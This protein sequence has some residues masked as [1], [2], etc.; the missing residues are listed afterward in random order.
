M[1]N[2]KV[3]SWALAVFF[4]LLTVIQG[5]Y[6]FSNLKIISSPPSEKWARGIKISSGNIRTNMDFIET[7]KGIYV[8]HTTEEGIKLILVDKLGEVIN[9]RKIDQSKYMKSLTLIKDKNQMYLAWISLKGGEK[10]FNIAGIDENL[11]LKDIERVHEGFK[12]N[13]IDNENY[14]VISKDGIRVYSGD[15]VEKATY[16]SESREYIDTLIQDESIYILSMHNNSF[17]VDTIKDGKKLKDIRIF[18]DNPSKVYVYEN[19]TF[20]KKD[21]NFVLTYDYFI[22]TK[23][24]KNY[25]DTYN[26]TYNMESKTYAKKMLST[27]G[28]KLKYID[29][30]SNGERYISTAQRVIDNRFK[31]KD[32]MEF[33]LNNGKVVNNVYV[34]HSKDN[35]F[36]PKVG[37]K[38]AIYGDASG[39]DNY[40]VYITSTETEFKD[41]AN[42]LKKSDYQYAFIGILQGLLMSL[43]YLFVFGLSWILPA[44]I[45]FGL[46]GFILSTAKEKIQKMFFGFIVL[47]TGGIQLY[48][49]YKAAY[50]HPVMPES[51][52]VLIGMAVIFIIY[53][54]S[55]A[56]AFKLYDNDPEVIPLVPFGGILLLESIIV[57]NIFV[58][59]I[60][61]FKL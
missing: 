21:E 22:K 11:E 51:F 46:G 24:E 41:N 3:T 60:G 30:M 34:S 23:K 47:V 52:G 25:L 19:L 6:Y 36:F 42:G 31:S 53:L 14:A 56:A 27:S 29:K 2:K 33:E 35:S 40:D 18:V 10:Y 43:V 58:P 20:N 9:S 44:L 61:Q 55:A 57:L 4:I 8:V 16:K 45:L 7:D 17:Y 54:V 39:I 48:Q 28:Y 26:I 12:I 32:I 15:L 59:Y 1:T 37:N 5:I 13:K 49:L 50:S 38:Y